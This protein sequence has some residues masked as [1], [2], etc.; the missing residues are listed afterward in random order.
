MFDLLFSMVDTGIRLEGC[1][2]AWIKCVPHVFTISERLK[3]CRY[4]LQ[5]FICSRLVEV[6]LH[7]I[8]Y[9]M[10]LTSCS[11]SIGMDGI[12][13]SMMLP[14]VRERNSCVE[15]IQGD[16]VYLMI[17]GVSKGDLETPVFTICDSR[18]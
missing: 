9:S 15:S 18:S 5:L 3:T 11:R 16:F 13:G 1:S 2:T 12:C 8:A 4:N 6:M 10:M 14:F 7:F 17:I